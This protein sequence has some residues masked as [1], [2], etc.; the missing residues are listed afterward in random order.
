MKMRMPSPPALAVAKT[1]VDIRKKMRQT[2]PTRRG[3]HNSM[4]LKRPEAQR[5]KTKSAKRGT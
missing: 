2:K 1:R 4:T 5:K 3:A